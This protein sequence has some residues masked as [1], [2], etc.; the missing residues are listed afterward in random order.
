MGLPV[1]EEG[2]DVVRGF[3]DGFAAAACAWRG[4]A[5]A[6]VVKCGSGSRE[7]CCLCLR[8]SATGSLTTTSRALPPTLRTSTAIADNAGVSVFMDGFSQSSLVLPAQHRSRFLAALDEKVG[9]DIEG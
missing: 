4:A 7:R 9:N 5:M 8:A 2:A 1:A 3:K 6:V